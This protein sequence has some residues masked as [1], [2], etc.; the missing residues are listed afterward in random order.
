MNRIRNKILLILCIIVFL[1]TYFML[2]G[3]LLSIGEEGLSEISKDP[4]RSLPILVCNSILGV[5]L[6]FIG[7]FMSNKRR[8]IKKFFRIFG[9]ITAVI[10]AFVVVILSITIIT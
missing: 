2:F 8:N 4:E 6:Y 10:S 1:A 9:L 3:K 5:E 7:F